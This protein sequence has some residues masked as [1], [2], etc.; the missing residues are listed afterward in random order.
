MDG[1]TERPSYRDARTHL[2]ILLLTMTKAMS[3]ALAMAIAMTMTITTI[4]FNLL[5]PYSPA[6]IKN[7]FYAKLCF[8]GLIDLK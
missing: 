4:D 3:K 1:R 5:L 8:A 2:N 7:G 6:A